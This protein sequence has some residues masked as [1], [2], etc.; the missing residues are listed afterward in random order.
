MVFIDKSIV[1]VD[2]E[3]I[4]ERHHMNQHNPDS[5]SLPVHAVMPVLQTKVR[6]GGKRLVVEAASE[7]L[8]LHACGEAAAGQG[9]CG[10]G[11]LSRVFNNGTHYGR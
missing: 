8:G 5:Q 3:Y 1:N 6:G 11:K 10:T 4:Y 2:T 7:F 9:W